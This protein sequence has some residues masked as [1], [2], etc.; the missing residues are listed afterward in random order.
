MFNKIKEML[1]QA[2]E[3]VAAEVE[4]VDD[5]IAK[6]TEWRP[7]KGGGSNF[8]TH[9]LKEVDYNRME[10]K[11]TVGAKIFSFIF[12][13]AGAGLALTFFMNSNIPIDRIFESADSIAILAGLIFAAIGGFMFYNFSKPIVFD[14]T[15]GMFWKGWKTPQ[16]YSPNNDRKNSRSLGDI[17]A[18]QIIAERVR[19]DNKSYISYELN[20]VFKDA[21]RINVVD[22][23]KQSTLRKDADRLAEFLNVPIWELKRA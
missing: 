7:L 2:A 17:H 13:I 1:D 3:E 4:K 9:Q 15:N 14:K 11:C 5:E 20:L 16:R 21:S 8:G 10:F 22:H 19:R 18:L 12:L 6:K 23:G